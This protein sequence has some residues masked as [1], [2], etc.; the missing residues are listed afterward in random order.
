[1]STDFP[2]QFAW[3]ESFEFASH[4]L[5]NF[6]PV[7]WCQPRDLIDDCLGTFFINLSQRQGIFGKWHVVFQRPSQ[8]EIFRPTR[9]R[10]TPRQP[11]FSS[12]SITTSGLGYTASF[13]LF[14][15]QC[16]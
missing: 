14:V 1:M 8:C 15:A 11:N 4:E 3:S 7:F 9:R 5:G 13:L 2:G 6:S 16:F 10:L 12:Q